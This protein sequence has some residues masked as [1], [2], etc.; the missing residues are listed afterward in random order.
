MAKIVLRRGPA[1]DQ[2]LTTGYLEVQGTKVRVTDRGGPVRVR[3][4]V[5]ISNDGAAGNTVRA[6]LSKN[7]FGVAETERFVK[8]AQGTG[9]EMNLEYFDGASVVGDEW[10]I[11]VR[12]DVSGSGV[13]VMAGHAALAVE[14]VSQD[15]AE[16]A[17]LVAV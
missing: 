1:T 8:V 9:V 16:V 2:D 7:G 3:G 12:M 6:Q 15:A 13:K 14:A 17:G 4:S 10:W 11:V 5:V